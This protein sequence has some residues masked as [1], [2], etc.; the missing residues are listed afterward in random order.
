MVANGIADSFINTA[1]QRRYE[2]SAYARNFL[3]R[4]INK[5][6][7]DLERS[8]RALVAYAQQQGI[9]NTGS[10]ATDGRSSE[11]RHRLAAGRIPGQA[12]RGAGRRDGAAGGGRRRLSPEP[13]DRADARRRQQHHGRC[14]SSAPQLEAEYQQ[15]RDVHEARPSGDAEPAD[16]RSTSST[17]RSHAKP[18][19]SLRAATI[20]CSPIIAP[21]CRPSA[22]FRRGSP[23][24]RATCST[25]AAAASSTR[26]CSA[27]WTPTAA[28]MT[29]CCSATRRSASPAASAW[30]RCRSSI[31]RMPRP[32][33]QAEPVPQP[34]LGLGL[35][36][37]AGIAGAI[38]LEFLNDTIKSREDV[39][40]KLSLPCLGIVPRTPAKDT[41]VED[42]KNPDVDRLGGLFGDRRGA[43]LQHR[44]R[45]CPR[46]CWSPAPGRARASRRPRW[47]SRRISRGASKRV[48][49]IDSDLRK[50]AFKAAD[51][52]GR[53]EQAAD[54]RR[55]GSKTMSSR[56]SIP[57]C[58]CCRA[59]RFR[60]IPPTCCRPAGSARSSPKRPR[61]FDLVVIDG[62]PT[63]GLA[64]CSAAR[65]GGRQRAVRHRKRQDPDA[66]RDR[67]AQPARGDG[68]AH[69][70]R[71][72]DQV[73]RR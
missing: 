30:R 14:A 56:P 55:Y 63:L 67:G 15:K 7:G 5:T 38:G 48:L 34:A 61:S 44:S 3:E 12:Q 20:P 53:P 72:A 37:L 27:R 47:R 46:C 21:R 18:V 71:D 65:R 45:A 59:G 41:F 25:C 50:P 35:G 39:R 32:A 8:E 31:A 70:R 54:D 73:R 68:H 49:L 52:Q 2:A 43:A 33:V 66:R 19:R 57:I 42:L 1:L 62:P 11:Q 58:G 10:T 17:G 23:R 29:R 64:D 40:K 26:S 9:I 36:L 51:R 69:P 24:S 22:R 60:P 28:S 13:G 16:R 4:Q 6:R